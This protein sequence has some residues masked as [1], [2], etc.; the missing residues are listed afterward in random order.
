VQARPLSLPE[1][2]GIFA[3]LA[4][5]SVSRALIPFRRVPEYSLR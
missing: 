2:G 3:E 5:D 1:A 4:V